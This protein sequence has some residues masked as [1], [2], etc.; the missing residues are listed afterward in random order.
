MWPVR[1]SCCVR[2]ALDD[3]RA[4]FADVPAVLAHLDVVQQPQQAQGQ[5]QTDLLHGWPSAPVAEVRIS[6]RGLL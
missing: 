2:H 3:I 6:A 1:P 4:R 5:T